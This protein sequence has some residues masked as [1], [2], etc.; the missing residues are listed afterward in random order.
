M[1]NGLPDLNTNFTPSVQF[2]P[3][4]S[5]M[6]AAALKEAETKNYLTQI[7]LKE[8]QQT[9]NALAGMFNGGNGGAAG[10][11]VNPY[12]NAANSL[13]QA[14][15]VEG[16]AKVAQIGS[17]YN[18]SDPESQLKKVE[19]ASKMLDLGLRQISLA[20]PENY[21]TIRQQLLSV[22]PQFS[23]H[24]PDPSVFTGPDDF[25]QYKQYTL[26]Q[27]MAYKD[28]V[29]NIIKMNTPK[30]ENMQMGDQNVSAAVFPGQGMGGI[31]P[32]PGA[33]GPKFAPQRPSGDLKVVEDPDSPTGFSY[34][35]LAGNKISGAPD[36]QGMNVTLSD[37]TSINVGGNRKGNPQ[38]GLGQAAQ[39]EVEKELLQSTNFLKNVIGIE[40]R[41]KPEYGTVFGQFKGKWSALKDKINPESLS[42]DQKQYLEDFKAYRAEAGQT[43]SQALK[44]LSG[45][46]VNPTE[47]KRAEAYLPNPGQ[48]WFDGDS[49]TETKA[50][51]SRMKDFL[52]KA[53]AR[54]NYVR[55]GGFSIQNTPIDKMD[56]IIQARAGQVEKYWKDYGITD[57]AEIQ[58]KTLTALSEEF[59]LTY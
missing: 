3:A 42:Q 36:K 46:A 57:K 29:D 45:V 58:K 24:L 5:M 7:L 50:K 27:G 56:E 18:K 31:K 22:N 43:F 51:I 8:K 38:T 13:L 40:Q 21:P 48:G 28:Q 23:A 47:F 14:G 26:Q 17:L 1:A 9:Q 59:G 54:A 20:T 16:A 44:D 55:R 39:N 11:D 10:G 41:F 33:T 6:T 30:I 15:N 37:G 49:P 12:Q 19:A 34:Q 4:K 25:A 53:V 52:R 2:D 35:D 32:I